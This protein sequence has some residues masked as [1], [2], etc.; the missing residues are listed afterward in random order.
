MNARESILKEMGKRRQ[1]E[2]KK[3][4]LEAISENFG[5]YTFSHAVMQKMLPKDIHKNVV[6]AMEGQEKIKPE[7]CR[8]YCRSH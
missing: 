2:P 7:I 5:K 4:E 3:V 6:K 8:Y 1:F